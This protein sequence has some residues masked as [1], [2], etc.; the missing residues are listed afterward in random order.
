MW[1]FH[2][3]SSRV[4]CPGRVVGSASLLIVLGLHIPDRTMGASR[5]NWACA[6]VVLA[7]IRRSS[8]LH[9]G[10]SSCQDYLVAIRPRV[11]E[12]GMVEA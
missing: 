4:L 3:Y 10:E 5:L 1:S 9:A 11:P 7:W 8:A 6:A 12:P 2:I